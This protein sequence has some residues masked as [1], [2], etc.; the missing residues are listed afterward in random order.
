MGY[1]FI[2]RFT[3]YVAIFSTI[4]RLSLP[5]LFYCHLSEVREI[6]Q[7]GPSA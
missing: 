3:N 7:H 2:K 1:T 4:F 6:R 5:Q